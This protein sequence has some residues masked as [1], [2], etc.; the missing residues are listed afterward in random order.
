[1]HQVFSWDFNVFELAETTKGQPLFV[2]TISLLETFDLL[3]SCI[4]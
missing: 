1:V 2:V 4:P 3:V